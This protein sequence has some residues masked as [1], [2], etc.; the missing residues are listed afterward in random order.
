MYLEKMQL[1][2][3]QKRTVVDVEKVAP[4]DDKKVANDEGAKSSA[5]NA[6][7][8]HISKKTRKR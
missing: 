4:V 6:K 1:R 7:D 3:M 2:I 5:D 8:A